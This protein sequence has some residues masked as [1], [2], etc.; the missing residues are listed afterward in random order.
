MG[1]Y[2]KLVPNP[3]LDGAT[4]LWVVMVYVYMFG[5][6][7]SWGVI[8]YVLPSMCSVTSSN[9]ILYLQIHRE[10]FANEIRAKCQVLSGSIDWLFQFV[11]IR[12]TPNV[13]L[14]LGAN[15]YIIWAA[16]NF[17]FIFWIYF[18][19]PETKQKSLEQIDEAFAESCTIGS[20]LISPNRKT[21]SYEESYEDNIK[22]NRPNQDA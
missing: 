14:T 9:T 19:V 16:F 4:W 21:P 17:F 10:I 11:S 13:L 6:A 22:I 5:Y 12:I 8:H 18:F 7:Y 2:A 20:K 3:S 1:I 15:T